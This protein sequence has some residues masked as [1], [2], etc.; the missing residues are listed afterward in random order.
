MTVRLG[1]FRSSEYHSAWGRP[2]D[3]D[4][5]KDPATVFDGEVRVRY[6]SGDQFTTIYRPVDIEVADSIAYNMEAAAR[7]PN[8]GYAQ[9]NGEFPR[10]GFYDELVRAGGD[11]ALIRN[12]CNSDC[13]AGT[14]ALLKT[15]GVPVPADMWT[16]N[17]PEILRATKRMIEIPLENCPQFEPYMMRGDVLYRPGHMAICLDNGPA[18]IPIPVDATGDTWQRL[19]AGVKEGTELHVIDNGAR[20]VAYLPAV[21]VGS[22]PWMMTGYNGRRGWSSSRY[23]DAAETVRATYTCYVRE[24]PGVTGRIFTVAESGDVL[25]ATGNYTEDIRGVEWYQVITDLSSLGW[26]SGRYSERVSI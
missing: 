4:M 12:L 15:A 10:T 20:A 24:R 5:P 23:L 16:G 8:V 22:R 14:A 2:G 9:N 7:N 21:M 13:S 19:S 25:T 6:F 26:I 3:Q 1:E 18:T 11:A 17:A